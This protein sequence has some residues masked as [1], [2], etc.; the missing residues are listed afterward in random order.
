MLSR[1]HKKVAEIALQSYIEFSPLTPESINRGCC[2][3]FAECLNSSY[4]YE[5]LSPYETY[6]TFD[7]ISSNVNLSDYTGDCEYIKDWQEDFMS[8]LGVPLPYFQEY[9]KKWKNTTQK[10]WFV[11]MCG[12][13]M[14]NIIMI[15]NA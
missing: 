15:L 9:R 6:C 4:A 7:F 3:D 5:G 11:T 10:V 8:S 1:K 2:D 12:C 14:E 13:M